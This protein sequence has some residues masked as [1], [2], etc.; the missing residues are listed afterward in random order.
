MHVRELHH[1][2][3]ER[4]SAS[5]RAVL[6]EIRRLCDGVEY[7]VPG[8]QETWDAHHRGKPAFA[9]EIEALIDRHGQSLE[10]ALFQARIS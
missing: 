6:D 3:E 10:A 8:K 9:D 2:E 7:K 4:I 1:F 5:V